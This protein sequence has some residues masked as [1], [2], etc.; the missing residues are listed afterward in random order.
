M[1]GLSHGLA[2]RTARDCCLGVLPPTST[3]A[4]IAARWGFAH[5]GRFAAVYRERYGHGPAESLYF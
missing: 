2:I 1:R 3:V 5:P 4:G